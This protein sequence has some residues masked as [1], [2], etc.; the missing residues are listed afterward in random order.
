MAALA[1]YGN[2]PVLISD[3]SHPL[4]SRVFQVDEID[5]QNSSEYASYFISLHIFIFSLQGK[6]IQR[7]RVYFLD[8]FRCSESVTKQ[9]LS[10][11]PHLHI[12]RKSEK[13]VL[14]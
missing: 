11:Q 9:E 8:E 5:Q 10:D 3:S 12:F 6:R 14:R 4:E 1:R 13:P 2:G 7:Q